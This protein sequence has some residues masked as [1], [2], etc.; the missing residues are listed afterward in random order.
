LRGLVL[1]SLVAAGC[2]YA[3]TR[4]LARR[5]FNVPETAGLAEESA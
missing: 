3:L 5:R 2:M 1:P 4:S